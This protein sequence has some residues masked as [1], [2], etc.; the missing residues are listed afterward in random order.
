MGA[1]LQACRDQA[2]R[3]ETRG[4]CR[5]LRE[6]LIRWQ[7]SRLEPLKAR[8]WFCSLLSPPHELHAQQLINEGDRASSTLSQRPA[9]RDYDGSSATPIP[10]PSPSP[11]LPAQDPSARVRVLR[12]VFRPIIRVPGGS[13]LRRGGWPGLHSLERN[14][15]HRKSGHWSLRQERGQ[16]SQV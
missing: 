5:G 16:N 4:G 2:P 6:E 3:P 13:V 14:I 12:D 11:P 10:P 7:F 8:T 15:S 9:N 1:N